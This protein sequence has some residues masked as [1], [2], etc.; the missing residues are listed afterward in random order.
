[1]RK[2]L[3][4]L[5]LLI[6]VVVSTVSAQLSWSTNAVRTGDKIIKLQL[7]YVAPGESGEGQLWDFSRLSVGYYVL[8]VVIGTFHES[9][10]IAKE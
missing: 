8:K 3:T 4:I 5:L 6:P 7:P 2:L 1:M 10:I 9:K